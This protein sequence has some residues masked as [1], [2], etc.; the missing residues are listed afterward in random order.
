M[1]SVRYIENFF[2]VANFV[3]KM[4]PGTPEERFVAFIFREQ[5]HNFP[6]RSLPVDCH[7]PHANLATR[8]NNEVNEPHS[9]LLEGRQTFIER[10]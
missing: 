10:T 8:R 4:P 2:Y 3:V 5:W 1:Y 7:V 9:N 6:I